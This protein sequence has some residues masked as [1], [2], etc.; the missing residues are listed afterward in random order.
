MFFPSL[1]IAP[2][3]SPAKSPLPQKRVNMKD[4]F[5]SQSIDSKLCYS[6][7]FSQFTKQPPHTHTLPSSFSLIRKNQIK[8]ILP[9]P[10]LVHHHVIFDIQDFLKIILANP[11]RMRDNHCPHIF[12]LKIVANLNIIDSFSNPHRRPHPAPNIPELLFNFE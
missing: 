3:P 5:V 7:S 11:S 4:V 1:Y 12:I 6:F 10:S 2:P 9:P 8:I